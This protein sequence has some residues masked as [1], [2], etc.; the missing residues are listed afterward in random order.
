MQQKLR[1][2][3]ERATLLASLVVFGLLPACELREPREIYLVPERYVGW[4]C[5]YYGEA[6]APSLENEGSFRVLRF[7]PDGVVRTSDPGKPG[8]G[9]EDRFFY[10]T[11]PSRKPIPPADIG[12]GGTFGRPS[13]PAER[14][15]VFLWI[16]ADSA[17]FRP[18]INPDEV[19][20]GPNCGPAK[21]LH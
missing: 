15:V 16:G 5:V 20:K 6:G 9:Y 17:R 21:D 8:K 3:I 13:D 1:M 11:G 18:A 10:V 14:Y 19:E 7:N 4:V 12:G 2:M